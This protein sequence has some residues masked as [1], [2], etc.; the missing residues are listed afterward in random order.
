MDKSL[1]ILV[2]DLIKSNVE[3]KDPLVESLLPKF[4]ETLTSTEKTDVV[5]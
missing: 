1:N 3:M 4:E 2:S 5:L